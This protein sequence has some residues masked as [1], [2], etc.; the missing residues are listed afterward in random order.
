MIVL[1]TR[2]E[3]IKLAPVIHRLRRHGDDFQTVVV[4]TAQHRHLMDQALGLFNIVPDVDLNL[5][6][7]R[8]ELPLLTGR[9]LESMSAVLNR[10][11]PDLVLIQGDTTTVFAAALAAFYHHIPVG[12]IEAGLRSHNNYNPFPEEMNRR[13]TTLMAAVHFAPTPFAKQMLIGEGVPEEQIVV[14]GNTGVDT[15][16]H[17]LKLSRP[18]VHSP[19]EDVDMAGKRMVLVTSHRRESWGV[20]LQNICEAVKAL[21]ER[22][23][24]VVVVYPVHPNP[25]VKETATAILQ[26][27]ERVYLLDPLDYAKFV[28]L[29][30]R[31]YMILTDSGGLQEEAPSLKKPLLLMRDTTER[32]EAFTAGLAKI[33]GTERDGILREADR[34]LNDPDLY[35]AMTNS[36]NPYG[37]GSAAARVVT[38]LVRWKNGRKPFISPFEEFDPDRF[39]PDQICQNY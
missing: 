25:I 23:P 35:A 2:P 15:L 12:H 28:H 7:E 3:A 19:L 17:T 1:G 14:T 36:G 20:E 34:L 31:A 38:A 30:R 21:V 11:R 32:P 13:M 9:V 29:M 5:M 27:T 37:D 8:Q 33:V 24:D 22:N 6:L 10:A 26:D 4:V 39:V 16:M 18:L